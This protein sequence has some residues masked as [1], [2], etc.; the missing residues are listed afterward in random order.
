MGQ[1]FLKYLVLRSHYWS[2][3]GRLFDFFMFLLLLSDWLVEAYAYCVGG[4]SFP[5]DRQG[6]DK[7]TRILSVCRL[8]RVIR[9]N[10]IVRFAA[11]VRKRSRAPVKS[12]RLVEKRMHNISVLRAFVKAH[13]HS[14]KDLLNL[15]G[16]GS[17][18][19]T[20]EDAKCILESRTL[21][22]RAMCILQQEM[23]MVDLQV[24]KDLDSLRRSDEVTQELRQFVNEAQDRGALDPKQFKMLAEPLDAVQAKVQQAIRNEC[25]G[26]ARQHRL[27]AAMEAKAVCTMN[28][29]EETPFRSPSEGSAASL[30][31]EDVGSSSKDE[32]STAVTA[33][34]AETQA[35][36]T[37]AAQVPGAGA[38]AGAPTA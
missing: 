29:T 21:V 35:G 8:F 3:V 38:G 12:S 31:A 30:Q 1:F 4:R 7:L 20:A 24:L 25:F 10:R 34:E 32:G 16:C 17:R 15:L 27:E 37:E 33:A 36:G 14:Q 19:H 13:C 22:Y 2:N 28:M 11:S 26:V 9:I 5:G 18:P 23:E 6:L